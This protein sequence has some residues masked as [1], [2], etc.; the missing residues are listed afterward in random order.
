VHFGS[1]G[2]GPMMAELARLS[3]HRG[4]RVSALPCFGHAAVGIEP[5]HDMYGKITPVR[6]YGKI[7]GAIDAHGGA[8][9]R[10]VGRAQ[11]IGSFASA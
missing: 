10:V 3:A 7:R 1:I 5:D 4:E 11:P 2:H 8:V 6:R 9:G